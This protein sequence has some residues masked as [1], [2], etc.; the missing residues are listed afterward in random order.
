MLH[1]L[2]MAQGSAEALYRTHCASCHGP[3]GAP[4][5]DSAVVQALGVVPANFTD[6]LFNSREPAA[7]WAMV[8]QHG[9]AASGLVGPHAGLRRHAER[10]SDH[11]GAGRLL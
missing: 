3:T 2:A 8:I 1:G 6:P 5:P 4:D 9:G 7:D 11:R 10:R